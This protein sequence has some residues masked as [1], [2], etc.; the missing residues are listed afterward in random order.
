MRFL[1]DTNAVIALLKGSP[2]FIER[3]RM[4]KTQDFGLPTIVAHELYFG[5][6]RSARRAENIARLDELRFEIVDFTAEDARTAGAVRAELAANGTPIGPYD[7]LIAAQALSRDLVL[8]T[9]NSREFSR[10]RSL[11]IED[12]E[13]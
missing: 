10:V 9:H 1:L 4:H 5:A 11:K 13:G 7:V 12:W 6:Y 8:V 3:L 2:A